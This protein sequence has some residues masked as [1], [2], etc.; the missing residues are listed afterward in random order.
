MK[1][2]E[3][4]P[5][6]PHPLWKLCLQMG[7]TDVIVKVKDCD[8]EKAIADLAAAGL[9]VVGFEGDMFDMS[10]IK[11]GLPNRDEA[12][13][14]Y[15]KYL[16]LMAKHGIRLLCYNFMVGTGWA[17]TG[18]REG[19]GGAKATY[20]SLTSGEGAASTLKLTKEQVWANYEYFIRAVMPTAERL[21]IRMGLHPDDPCLDA[22]GGY[23]RIFGSVEAFDRAYAICP[24]AS[25]AVTFCQANFKLMGADLAET[26]K[27]FGKR[28]AF[29][30]VRDVEGDKT[31][32][33]ELFHDQGT[34]DQFAL[35]R[36]YRALGL[37]VPVR[38]DH[39][40]EME[41]DRLLTSNCEPGYF[42]LGRLFANG[43]L[44]A[45][46]KG[47]KALLAVAAALIAG[48]V[49]A[50]ALKGYSM[51]THDGRRMVSRTVDGKEV[52]ELMPTN[53]LPAGLKPVRPWELYVVKASHTDIGLHNS[54]YIQRHGSIWRIEEAI[55][56]I[57]AD[58]RADDDPAAF[59]YLMEG[60]W[61][62]ENY[63]MD[64]GEAAAR[65]V[66]TNYIAR[67]RLGVSACCAGNMTHVY[68]PVEIERSV[69]FKRRLAEKW[70]L[71]VRTMVMADYP[72][73]SWS[74]VSPYVRAGIENLFFAPNKYNPLPTTI[75]P[76]HPTLRWDPWNPDSGAGGNR[77]DVG[78]ES[79]VPML[80]W[81]ESPDGKD[82]MLVWSSTIYG[83]AYSRM[84]LNP[85]PDPVTALP[86]AEKKAPAFLDLLESRVPYDIWLGGA[87]G[88]DE[89][90][91]TR[92]ANFAAKWNAKWATPT[93]HIVGDLDEPF[94]KVRAR[95]GDRI[96]V[97]R[98]EM[99]SGWAQLVNAAPDLL[100]DK[101][102]ADRTLELAERLGERAGTLDRT[103]V[104]AAWQYLIYNDEHSYGVSGYVGRRIF[105]TWMQHR[106]WIERASAIASN[107]L[108][109]AT[110]K[111][112]IRPAETPGEEVRPGTTA[113]N[114]FYRVTVNAKGELASLYDK[115]L[116]R[117]LLGGPANRLLYTRDNHRSWA[118]TAQLGAEIVQRV[119]LPRDVKR[120]DVSTEIRHATDLYNRDRFKRYGYLEFPFAV[121]GGRFTAHLNGVTMEPY[122]EAHPLITDAYVAV[123]DWCKVENG[124]FGVGLM[125]RDSTLTEFG[126][127][128]PDK[129]CYTGVPP[130]DKSAI[131]PLLFNDWLQSHHASGETMDFTFRFAITSF[132]KGRDDLDRAAEDWLNPYAAW[133][134]EHE[135]GPV[136]RDRFADQPADWTGLI[137][138]PR[139]SH[140]EKDGQMYL[141][142]GAEMSPAFDHYE[143]YRS[144]RPDGGFEKIANVT[145]EAPIGIPYRVARYVDLG[146]GSHRRY[147]YRLRKV[148]RDH[149]EELGPVFS[150]VTRYVSEDERT[151]YRGGSEF[152]WLGVRYVGAHTISWKPA[153]L[154]GEEVLF[155]PTKCPCGGEV[156]GGI[157]VCWPWFG[158]SAGKR[159][160][161][162]ANC[163]PWTLKEI[164]GKDHFI[165]TLDSSEETKRHWPHDFHLELQVQVTSGDSLRLA[166]TET[167][168]GR[169]PFESAWGFR[170]HFRVSDPSAVSVRCKD[171]EDWQGS[172]PGVRTPRKLGPGESRT[173]EM[174]VVVGTSV[175]AGVTPDL[176][177]GVAS[178][179]H[180]PV[181]GFERFRRTLAAFD[182]RRVDAVLICGDMTQNGLVRELERFRDEWRRAFPEN[183]RSDGGAVVPL[184]IYGDHDTGGYIHKFE[185][186]EPP[187]KLHGID[188]A[189][190]ERE[191]IPTVG[192]GEAWKRV[193][194]E[195]WDFVQVRDV[196]G[197]RFIL[198]HYYGTIHQQTPPGLEKAFAA[199]TQGLDPARPFFFVQHRVFPETVD[200]FP[201]EKEWWCADGDVSKKLLSR[202]PNAVGICG[203]AH[204]NLLNDGNLWK[205]P[206]AAVEVPSLHNL[207]LPR[208]TG[209]RR[210]FDE[211]SAQCLIMNVWKDRVV[212]ERIDAMKDAAIAPEWTIAVP[213]R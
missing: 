151:T 194:G 120:V 97:L 149:A 88:D 78:Y 159:K 136:S 109:K 53:A 126:E 158:E 147:W 199:A 35:M 98:G 34:T 166:L 117:E 205:G 50:E 133:M 4:V 90:V 200:A 122:R 134:R 73:V 7:I 107:E 20:F 79:K 187:C 36:T 85:W 38:G 213:R 12:I 212:F 13:A 1:L 9:R 128:H 207:G 18:V 196:K 195:D 145:N 23:A 113:E 101:F 32:F 121:P 143:I 211:Q 106:D 15:L 116:K 25:N 124:E 208:S 150:G 11:E 202:H 172:N 100:A 77:I 61:F 45:L 119:F 180:V 30:H 118:D 201:Y 10:P 168:T 75:W 140:G 16:E 198:S 6:R 46:L 108:R 63:V 44:K 92:F 209:Q 71:D 105:E 125:S 175:P 72:G 169:E 156:Q 57:D 82:R 87:Y 176:R 189:A 137:T 83:D 39:V 132:A 37:D 89:Y 155:M 66:V 65:N 17:R 170:P 21:G 51:V 148:Y 184:F 193:F 197:Y 2:V 8:P 52:F 26:A 84:G 141:L 68:S 190:M 28:I 93:F 59:R 177:V 174:T 123:R 146:L 111:L 144:E 64:R 58:T 204:S 191:V 42:T 182:A 138:S 103:S 142:W 24:S 210:V 31:D 94:E 49:S 22:L 178:D 47:T 96:P 157:S 19:R 48:T 135:V 114:R 70:G 127:I 185:N 86:A 54:Q 62:W 81:W 91:N 3:F 161:G 192:S 188:K 181:G 152:G 164:R 102:E 43:Y 163:L 206:F 112:G 14:K 203:H 154:K 29:V 41:G 60:T 69:N 115:E 40:P 131:Y 162:F 165:F 27:H 55:K 130:A 76:R 129:T 179:V 67:G 183:R 74:V 99:T 104:D 139:A 160:D 171:A 80:F 33:T 5:P 95:F 186:G 110:A 173:H 56:A 153:T 167:N